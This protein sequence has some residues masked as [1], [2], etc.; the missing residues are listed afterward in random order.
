MDYKGTRAN[1]FD[2]LV[3]EKQIEHVLEH[4][5][6]DTALDVG[7]GIGLFTE[8]LPQYFEVVAG[9]DIDKD[10]RMAAAQRCPDI[11]FFVGDAGVVEFFQKY[12]DIFMLNVLEHVE[13]P[14][15]I[16]RNMARYLCPNGKMHIVVPNAWSV[17]RLLAFRMGLIV[18]VHHLPQ[19]QIDLYGHK[20]VYDPETLRLDVQE[21]GL[22]ITSEDG[23][24]YKPLPNVDMQLLGDKH[25]EGWLRKWVSGLY[26]FGLNCP[27]NCASIYMEAR[28]QDT[29]KCSRLIQGVQGELGTARSIST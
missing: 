4:I 28:C 18:D 27:S 15:K 29:A 9:L 26:E 25:G 7:C 8:R 23:I 1:Y 10:N 17:H 24:V 3:G 22:C 19:D 5:V 16:L 12:S 2:Y 11:D 21:A 20:R 13:D 14:I 6:G